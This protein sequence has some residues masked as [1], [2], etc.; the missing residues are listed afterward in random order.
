[1]DAKQRTVAANKIMLEKE[2]RVAALEREVKA[3]KADT[4]LLK[5]QLA[6]A[7]RGMSAMEKKMNRTYHSGHT[8]TIAVNR[9]SQQLAELQK[10]FQRK[11]GRR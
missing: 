5:K 7:V 2:K 3:L 11:I 1:M 8:S 9:L 4:L 10:E 6:Q